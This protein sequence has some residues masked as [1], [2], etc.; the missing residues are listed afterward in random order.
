M[1]IKTGFFDHFVVLSFFKY[2]FHNHNKYDDIK[3]NTG[4]NMKA[5]ESGYEK[6]KISI[7]L[8]AILVNGHVCAMDYRTIRKGKSMF[9]SFDK[10][11]PFPSL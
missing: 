8:W 4:K 11:F 3:D 6:E 7:Q 9:G 1:P 5:M 10:M 2:P